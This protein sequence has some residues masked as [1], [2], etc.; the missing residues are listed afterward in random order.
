[1]FKFS[2]IVGKYFTLASNWI[3]KKS[4]QKAFLWSESGSTE[5]S[6][7]RIRRASA[8][9]SEIARGSDLLSIKKKKKKKGNLFVWNFSHYYRGGKKG[10][11]CNKNF[12]KLFEMMLFFLLGPNEAKISYFLYFSFSSR[13]ITS[14]CECH[15]GI[16]ILAPR[17]HM[18]RTFYY[19]ASASTHIMSVEL[20]SNSIEKP[21]YREGISIIGGNEILADV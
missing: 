8:Q 18:Y 2:P 10:S 17:R 3:I 16:L 11:N 12:L 1:M 21:R 20:Q 9:R 6:K 19:F 4:F 13:E 7:I 5:I 15:V 14:L